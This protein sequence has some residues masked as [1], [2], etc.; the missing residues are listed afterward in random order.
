MLQKYNVK[1]DKHHR[2]KRKIYKIILIKSLVILSCAIV[3]TPIDLTEHTFLS[4]EMD[5]IVYYNDILNVP[6]RLHLAIFNMDKEVYFY[7]IHISNDNRTIHYTEPPHTQ[8]FYHWHSR[9][10]LIVLSVNMNDGNQMAC[11]NVI[12][13]GLMTVFYNLFYK[14]FLILYYICFIETFASAFL[15]IYDFNLFYVNLICFESYILT[16]CIQTLLLFNFKL[17][18]LN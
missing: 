18:D 9:C 16:F 17:Y 6:K 5:V 2:R 7:S 8:Q 11:M 12:Y 3:I 14:D 4:F 13:N 10:A 15:C 1:D